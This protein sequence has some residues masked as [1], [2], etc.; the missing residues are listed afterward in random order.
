MTIH[1]REII[2][3]SKVE[4]A[5]KQFMQQFMFKRENLSTRLIKA[6]FIMILNMFDSLSALYKPPSI[7]I[8]HLSLHSRH[9][10]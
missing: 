9:L 2:T 6:E 10:V 7:E 1:K 3:F 5:Y 8:F 4:H